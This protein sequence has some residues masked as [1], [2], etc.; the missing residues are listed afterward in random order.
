VVHRTV[1][2]EDGN[3][4]AM[5]L[6]IELVLTKLMKDFNVK[7]THKSVDVIHKEVGIPRYKIIIQRR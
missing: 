4:V 2:L 5:F 3:K 7:Y 6:A 1:Q